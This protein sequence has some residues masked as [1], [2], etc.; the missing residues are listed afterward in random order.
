MALSEEQKLS[1]QLGKTLARTRTECGYTQEQVAEQMD[2]NVETISRF[3]RGA[4]LPSLTRLIELA[5]IYE[6]PV[7]RLLRRGSSRPSDVAEELADTL[8]HLTDTDRVWVRQW[9]TELCE[10][11]GHNAAHTRAGKKIVR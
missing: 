3:E 11:L 9:L 10:R 5:D 8:S 1:E 2:I 7:S 6:V 4:V